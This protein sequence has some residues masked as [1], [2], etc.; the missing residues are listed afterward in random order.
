MS[1]EA[2][3]KDEWTK[4]LED[5]LLQVA[6][7]TEMWACGECSPEFALRSIRREV[8]AVAK[9]LSDGASPK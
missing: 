5:K 1:T 9:K 4:K 3:P 6:I 7:T 8:S 2:A